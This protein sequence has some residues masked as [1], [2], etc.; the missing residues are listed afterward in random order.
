M[1]WVDKMKTGDRCTYTQRINK[2]VKQTIR[3][4]KSDL[5]MK[6]Y[7]E[8]GFKNESIQESDLKME[9]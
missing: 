1:N 9:Q 2:N 8:V 3:K 7:E 6:K 4:R 5:K